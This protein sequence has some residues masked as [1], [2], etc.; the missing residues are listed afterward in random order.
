ML[1]EQKGEVRLQL[2]LGHQVS[3][4]LA[5]P[6]IKTSRMF[7]LKYFINLPLP[8]TPEVSLLKAH[9]PICGLY[10]QPPNW[11]PSFLASLIPIFLLQPECQFQS[12]PLMDQ[13]LLRE[14]QRGLITYS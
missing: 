4:I 6:L 2:S 7:A 10:N 14:C 5:P 12:G 11:P 13:P 1:R 8:S 3:V 9:H